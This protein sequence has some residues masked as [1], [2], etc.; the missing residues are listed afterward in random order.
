M[1]RPTAPLNFLAISSRVASEIGLKPSM[2]SAVIR[3]ISS[4]TAPILMPNP[5][6]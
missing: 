6:I 5:N 1:L 4:I 2:K 3:G